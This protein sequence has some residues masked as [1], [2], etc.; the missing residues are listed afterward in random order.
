MRAYKAE[1]CRAYGTSAIREAENSVII[2]DQIT[3]RT[4]IEI[5]GNLNAS[6]PDVQDSRPFLNDPAETLPPGGN[7]FIIQEALLGIAQGSDFYSG[8][9]GD[10]IL[11]LP[12]QETGSGQ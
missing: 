3:Q 6:A 12:Q 1:A 4:G 7:G 10:L 8:P 2:Q 9:L 5:K 11:R